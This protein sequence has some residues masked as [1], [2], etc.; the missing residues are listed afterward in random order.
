[1]VG[2]DDA[3]LRMRR[4]RQRLTAQAWGRRCIA[5]AREYEV[6]RG[7]GGID[8]S[9]EVAPP[10][11]D[12][13][14]GLIDTPGLL[15]WLE[16]TAPPLLSFETVALDPAPDGRVVRFQAA[17][18]EQLFDIAE[19]ERGPKGPAH[20]AQNQLGLGLPPFENRRASGLLHQFSRR[21]AGLPP[22]LHHIQR[23]PMILPWP[24]AV[25]TEGDSC[26]QSF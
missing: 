12:T 1:M 21:P 24:G 5:H 17:L 11:L 4:N 25:D 8:G 26:V 20:S 14:A 23:T 9:G 13:N 7:A 22:T 2:V 19:R 15:G 10:A 16:M 6:D 18:A 3:G